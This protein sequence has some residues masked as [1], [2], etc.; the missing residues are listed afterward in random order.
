MTNQDWE[1][2]MN[3]L[4]DAQLATQRLI[5]HNEKS[6]NQRFED[7]RKESKAQQAD[8]NDRFGTVTAAVQSL[9]TVGRIHEQRLAKSEDRLARFEELLARSEER[10]ARS[11]DRLAKSEDG[12]AEMRAA[13]SSLIQ[14]IDRFIRGQQRNGH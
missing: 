3:E 2:R 9:I 8:W 6:W 12:V 14:T 5:E 11:E 7:Q 1:L 13:L 10:L 4:R